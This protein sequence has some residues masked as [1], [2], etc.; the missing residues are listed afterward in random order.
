MSQFTGREQAK[1]TS[2][3]CCWRSISRV[4]MSNQCWICGET[5]PRGQPRKVFTIAQLLEYCAS[6]RQKYL[7]D[8]LIGKVCFKQYRKDIFDKQFQN[9]NLCWNRL[10]DIEFD[11]V[12]V[13]ADL[14]EARMG[15]WISSLACCT[16]PKCADLHREITAGLPSLFDAG[17]PNSLCPPGCGC[18]APWQFALI[19]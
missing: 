17:L 4:L 2:D 19:K 7:V 14:D 8:C 10:C 15:K 1:V 11:T 13:D 12:M 3:A 5:F 18:D 6:R 9:L 16:T